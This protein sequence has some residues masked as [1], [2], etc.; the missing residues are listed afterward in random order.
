LKGGGLVLF[1]LSDV[2]FSLT[3]KAALSP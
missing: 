1:R 3:V 2:G